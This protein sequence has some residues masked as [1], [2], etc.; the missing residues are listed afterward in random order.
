LIGRLRAR[1]GRFSR[2]LLA[3]EECLE[4]TDRLTE[5]HGI[6]LALPLV[7]QVQ[8]L[9]YLV[10]HVRLGEARLLADDGQ[11]VPPAALGRP[12]HHLGTGH[13]T[14]RRPHHQR[15]FE[16]EQRLVVL[17]GGDEL[18]GGG[19]QGA[20]AVLAAP[21]G[22]RELGY[23]LVE[24]RGFDRLAAF[25]AD[26]GQRQNARHELRP[27][28]ERRLGHVL[29]LV[30]CALPG[31]QELEQARGADAV[32]GFEGGQC[33]QL[34]QRR[35]DVATSQG[36][37]DVPATRGE[38]AHGVG[39]G[40]GVAVEQRIGRR[41]R[42]LEREDQ[43]HVVGFGRA[44]GDANLDLRAVRQP[45]AVHGQ[46]AQHG[47]IAGVDA[48]V[49]GSVDVHEGRQREIDG[50]LPVGRG[51]GTE[52]GEECGDHQ[53]RRHGQEAESTYVVHAQAGAARR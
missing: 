15:A 51:L 13:G 9:R 30:E 20:T 19:E 11:D 3:R 41:R 52:R 25:G 39:L 2:P 49:G 8:N 17:P 16:G 1:M 31:E 36:V 32:L 40:I 28:H 10:A 23:L 38:V 48:D 4:E 18:A 7:D 21:L 5:Q 22:H 50:A 14:Q 12:P 34:P 43:R 24:R 29:R 46:K 37:L 44:P 47:Q 6:V 33:P 42:V 35:R 27:M 26:H 45:P 53:G